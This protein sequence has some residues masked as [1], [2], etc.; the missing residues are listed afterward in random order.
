MTRVTWILAA[1][2]S[3]S[4]F[5]QGESGVVRDIRWD[6]DSAWFRR[7]GSWRRVDLESGAIEQGAADAV[8]PA[9]S[10][11]PRARSRPGAPARGR[12]RPVEV[13][14]SGE[15]SALSQKGNLFVKCGEAEKRAVTTDGTATL[16]YGTASWVYG[17]ELDQTTGMWWS[18]DSSRLAFYKFDDAKVP[19]FHLLSGLTSL[20]TEVDTE[21]YPKPGD[22]NPIATLG[23]LD[24]S[25]FCESKSED[26]LA[27]VVW[28][29]V[30]DAD[31]YIYG[32]EW[33][34]SGAEL[35]FHRLNRRHDVLELC[36]ADAES[37]A[38]RV[39]LREQQLH[40][41]HH[42]PE[43]RFLADGRRFI[44]ASERTGF[45]HYEI[46]SLDSPHT[47]ALT[48]GPFPC[49]RIE[50]VDEASG[51]LYFTAFPAATAVNQQLM[52][53]RLDG[54]QQRRMTTEDRHYGRF[55]IAPGGDSFA[56]TDES[57]SRRPSTRLYT[58]TGKLI[59]TLAE[60]EGDP[61]AE[62]GVRPPELKV[63]KA[64]DGVTDLY[65]IVHFPKGFDPSREW[66]IIVSVYGGP[67]FQTI[68]GTFADQP[69]SCDHGFVSLRVDNRGTPGRGK[70]FE[71]AT[72][73]A[74]GI[75]DMDDQAAAVTQ[76]GAQPGMDEKRVGITG[77]SYGGYLSAL[78]LV[79]HPEVFAAAVAESGPTDWR[80]YDS[81]YTERFMRTPQENQ[82]GYDAGSVVVHA[83]KMRG[84]FMLVH[85]MEDD[86]V[87]PNNAWALAQR[88]YDRGFE[89]ELMLFPRAGHGGFGQA[90][91]AAKWRFFKDHLS[92]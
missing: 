16:R 24:A 45:K 64:A 83:D 61:W 87:H 12:Q 60:P 90:E 59:A 86:N 9:A 74:L 79:R 38:V 52:V 31:Q 46:R 40:W 88:L 89:F 71:D 18:P 14:P 26:P 68:H 1:A 92:P 29:S 5:A 47:V 91:D 70:L 85:G 50:A 20:R 69:E 36:A 11:R 7:D 53:A 76:L 28:V 27:H 57:V 34:P 23:I 75:A 3:A 49:G 6:A 62:Q 66:P 48:A 2:L 41:N 42:L 65:G 81:I 10:D 80:Q 4:A 67:Y 56:A 19:Q 51:D 8:I 44:W 73:M 78:S 35:L 15:R 22:P 72:Y 43:M 32:V 55:K 84:H 30:G 54:S 58:R 37:G 63:F 33:S 82:A 77:L 25:A 39:I 13:A 17:E 21:R